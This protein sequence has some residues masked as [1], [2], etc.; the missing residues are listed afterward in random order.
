MANVNLNETTKK[1]IRDLQ[2]D[3]AK[4]LDKESNIEVAWKLENLHATNAL[5]KGVRL[6]RRS[7][8]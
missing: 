2:N 6:I 5:L 1:V 7:L 4:L 8:E 3:L